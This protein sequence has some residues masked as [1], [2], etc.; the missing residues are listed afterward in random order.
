ME[1]IVVPSAATQPATEPL[2]G[3]RATQLVVALVL[4]ALSYQLSATMISPVLPQIAA[5]LDTNLKDAAWISSL[6]LL[7]GAVAGIILGRW[8]DMVGRRTALLLV[9]AIF[10]A[11]TLLCAV[12]PNLPVMLMGRAL[13]GASSAVFQ[14]SYVTMREQLSPKAFGPVL[15]IVTAVNGGAAGVDG[16][17]SGLLTEHYGF[18]AVFFFILAA[19]VTALVLVALFVPKQSAHAGT[20]LKMDWGGAAALAVGLTAASLGLEQA[21]GGGWTNPMLLVY[22]GLAAAAFY[23]FIQIEQRFSDP[24]IAPRHLASRK[25]WPVL[26][27][28]TFMLAGVFALMNFTVVVLGQ[29]A[30]TGF[31][32]PASLT[33]LLFLTPAA[34][35]G[36][37]CAPVAG[38]L[39][40]RVGWLTL[41]RTGLIATI[42]I[43]AFLTL[44]FQNRLAVMI[45][46]GL[47]GIFYNGLAL[48]MMNG[49]GVLNSP[50][51][52]PTAL[53]SLNGASFGLGAGLGISLVAP[54]VASGTEDGYRLAF[55]LACGLTLCAC[56]AS[57]W[58]AP[59]EKE[60]A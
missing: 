45:G 48:T 49:L 24:L 6:F 21:A 35:I 41:L 56:A 40:N 2:K 30:E 44:Q 46:V 26:L 4:A 15:G 27:T 47:L 16:Y 55:A 10:V 13:Q 37:A 53:P 11:G 52:T 23:A 60:E 42:V 25:A 14:I 32:M 20:P 38:W 50:K 9:M 5:D 34:L 31:G 33:A 43:L 58:I 36:M 28:T 39:A 7:V 54:F 29:N 22:L 1:A 18:R 51:E 3:A 57:F 8:S 12:A 59:V 19:G 17:L